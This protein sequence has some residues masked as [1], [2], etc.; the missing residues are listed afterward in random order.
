MTYDSLY[1]HLRRFLFEQTIVSP[2]KVGVALVLEDGDVF[3]SS[4][5]LSLYCSSYYQYSLS[6]WWWLLMQ[7]KVSSSNG[8][9]IKY[10]ICINE[11][12]GFCVFKQHLIIFH[13]L[14]LAQTFSW[15]RTCLLT[16]KRT[17]ADCC[18]SSVWNSTRYAW[19]VIQ[20]RPRNS[21]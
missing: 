1:F 9:L 19:S 17:I 11:G 20:K 13:V 5:A 6:E 15:N 7:L 16:T 14:Y 8:Y 2:P 12:S 10:L 4:E 3:C 21:C 18:V